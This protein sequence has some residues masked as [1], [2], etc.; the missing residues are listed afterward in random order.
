MKGVVIQELEKM[1]S[2]LNWKNAN[3]ISIQIAIHFLLSHAVR[4]GAVLI[5]P[6]PPLVGPAYS[7]MMIVF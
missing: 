1:V 6:P 3:A 5:I 4:G 7:P 2:M